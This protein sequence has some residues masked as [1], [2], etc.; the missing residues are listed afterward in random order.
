MRLSHA[1]AGAVFLDL[2]KAELP[3]L[4]PG[5]P[6]QLAERLVGRGQM[7]RQRNLEPLQIGSSIDPSP[8]EHLLHDARLD[9]SAVH[10]GREAQQ[11]L[12]VAGRKRDVRADIGNGD[13]RHRECNDR[14]HVGR[15]GVVEAVADAD[16]PERDVKVLRP[17]LDITAL[18][19]HE[20][21]GRQLGRRI[22]GRNGPA[23]GRSEQNQRELRAAGARSLLRRRIAY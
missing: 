22:V 21:A 15:R 19:E 16:L 4:A 20:T 2:G 8:G 13:V 3:Q 18:G 23:H 7:R 12:R 5:Q 11:V 14:R 9:R 1:S 10:R 6:R 17:H